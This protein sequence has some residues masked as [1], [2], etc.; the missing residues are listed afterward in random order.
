MFHWPTRKQLFAF[1]GWLGLTFGLPLFVIVFSG[2]CAVLSPEIDRLIHPDMRVTR[3]TEPEAAPLS[4]DVLATRVTEACPG[5]EITL[6]SKSDAPNTAWVASVAYAP[7]DHRRVHFDPYTGTVQGQRTTFNAQSFFRIFHKQFYILEGPAWPHGRVIVCFFA[8][9]L[10]CAALTGLLFYKGWW[11]HLFQ[12]R[13][14]RGRRVFTSDLH[15]LAGVWTLLLALLFAIT[16]LWYLTERLM[17]DFGMRQHDPVPEI[18]P[19]I[20]AARPET[21]RPLPL[22]TLVAK[23]RGAYPGFEPT[24]ILLPSSAAQA[25]TFYG[26][27]TAALADHD[28]VQL[29]PY[30]GRVLH[31][32]KAHESGIGGRLESLVSPLHFGRFG[33][34]ITKLLWSGAGLLIAAGILAGAMIWWLRARQA[35]T[36]FFKRPPIGSIFSLGLNLAILILAA[37]ST[38]AFIRGQV[39]GTQT[40]APVRA[41][42]LAEIGPW[43]LEVAQTGA[44]TR[45]RFTQDG[46]PNYRHFHAWR[47]GDEQPANLKPLRGTLNTLRGEVAGADSDPLQIAIESWSGKVFR[48]T[49]QAASAATLTL[50]NPPGPPQVPVAL[51]ILV[52]VFFAVILFPAL[53]WLARIR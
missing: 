31:M 50:P 47:G 7:R 24:S 23:A 32:T 49:L 11:K 39:A 9:V 19:D 43:K 17:E 15:R 2:A 6:L 20:L 45:I 29:D 18:S 4:W 21:L 28:R 40:L 51:V 10:L 12:L 8:I 30:D 27:G 33:G 37:F 38:V 53:W 22:D 26:N 46:R 52:A 14:T 1:H 34:W 36:G 35:T 42:G 44:D 13:L 25:I 3:P 16:G 41:L 48:D 5:G